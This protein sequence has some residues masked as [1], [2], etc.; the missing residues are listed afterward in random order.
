MCLATTRKSLVKLFK[1]RG[2]VV[3][4]P[5]FISPGTGMP[6]TLEGSEYKTEQEP[7]LLVMM[8]GAPP[9]KKSIK[10][11]HITSCPRP[12]TTSWSPSDRWQAICQSTRAHTQQLWHIC[13][14]RFTSGVIPLPVYNASIAASCLPHMCVSAEVGCWDLNCWPPARQSD[15]LPTRPRRPA[16]HNRSLIYIKMYQMQKIIPRQNWCFAGGNLDTLFV[17]SVQAEQ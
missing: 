10:V 12:T 6:T 4:S 17:A 11:T 5:L 15:A 1:W 14:L 9:R 8:S 16:Y 2:T 3:A 7:H 13:S